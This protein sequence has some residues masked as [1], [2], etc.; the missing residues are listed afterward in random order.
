MFIFDLLV[1][2][3]K[4]KF[5]QR[6]DAEKLTEK[7]WEEITKIT[8]KAC[9]KYYV[10]FGAFF[11]VGIFLSFGGLNLLNLGISS[12]LITIITYFTRLVLFVSTIHA[13]L[14]L[15]NSKEFIPIVYIG[16]WMVF[17]KYAA[18]IM[19]LWAKQFNG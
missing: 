11:L 7:D 8:L 18:P 15:H 19:L 2:R 1:K 14:Y 10:F 9:A 17:F 5:G 3:T 4:R 16:S 6:K 13:Y 12:Y